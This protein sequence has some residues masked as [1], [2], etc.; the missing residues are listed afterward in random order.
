MDM[1]KVTWWAIQYMGMVH[2]SHM[3]RLPIHDD[4]Q[5]LKHVF[6]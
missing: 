5:A 3:Q 1:E 4:Q 6:D 2:N